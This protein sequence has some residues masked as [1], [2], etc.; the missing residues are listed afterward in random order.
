MERQ[1]RRGRTRAQSWPTRGLRADGK[2]LAVAVDDLVAQVVAA[3][4]P[5]DEGLPWMWIALVGSV[6]VAIVLVLWLRRVDHAAAT[7]S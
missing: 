4:P 3:T 7:S 6:V 2:E 1:R 5:P